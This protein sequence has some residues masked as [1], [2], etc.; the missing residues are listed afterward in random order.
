MLTQ[1]T[2]TADCSNIKIQAQFCSL[3]NHTDWPGKK[4][5]NSAGIGQL[6]TLLDNQNANTSKH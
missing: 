2:Q 5:Q 1:K 3:V 6:L 4:Q